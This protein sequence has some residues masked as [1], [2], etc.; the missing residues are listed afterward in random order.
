[1]YYRRKLSNGMTNA[2]DLH[3]ESTPN[4]Y[5]TSSD[6]S[7]HL[8]NSFPLAE[9]PT[10]LADMGSA[11]QPQYAV[12]VASAPPIYAVVTPRPAVTNAADSGKQQPSASAP[13]LSL[14]P[15]TTLIDN[16][17]YG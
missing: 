4:I 9:R 13:R 12:A 14:N 16:D 1:M 8:G 15:D 3:N 10:K 11:E 5:G 2:G 6:N 7:Q 17:L